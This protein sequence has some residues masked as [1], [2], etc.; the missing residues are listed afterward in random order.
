MLI[1]QL[2]I[3]DLSVRLELSVTNALNRLVDSFV[4]D[5]RVCLS[6][7]GQLKADPTNEDRPFMKL[8]RFR[9]TFTRSLFTT[10]T[11]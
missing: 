9:L 5:C 4:E 2:P 11:M 7:A 8:V 10:P 6:G 3:A 1:L